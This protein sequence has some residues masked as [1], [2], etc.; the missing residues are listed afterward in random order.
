VRL[1]SLATTPL[2][3]RLGH[4]TDDGIPRRPVLA[5]M[6]LRPAPAIPPR[7]WVQVRPRVLI[8]QVPRL[9]FGVRTECFCAIVFVQLRDCNTPF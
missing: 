4:P 3:L 2:S 9:Y 8:V 5:T 1:P 7:V 6:C